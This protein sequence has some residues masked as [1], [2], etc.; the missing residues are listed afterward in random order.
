M[1]RAYLVSEHIE[2]QA[3]LVV[4]CGHIYDCTTVY[5]HL[6]SVLDERLQIESVA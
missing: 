3:V 2:I 1:S 4:P 5:S 6:A